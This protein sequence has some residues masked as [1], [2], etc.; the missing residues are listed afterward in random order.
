GGRYRLHERLGS[1]G[2]AD[3]YRGEHL[4]LKVPRAI[5][6]LHTRLT[7]ANL[8]KFEQEAR[9]VANLRHPNILQIHDFDV[10][11]GLPFLVMDYAPSGTLRDRHPQGSKLPPETVAVY[12]SYIADA[13]QFAHDQNPPIVHRDIKPENLL[14]GSRGEIL[15]SDFGI[16]TITTTLAPNPQNVAGTAAY[17]APEQFQGNPRR[18][19]DQ[20][21]LG[22]VVY[23]WLCGTR[24]FKGDYL[25]LGYK[26]VHETP[27]PL[28]ASDKAPWLL[29]AVEQGV[30]KALAKDPKE[31]YPST[32]EF[33]GAFWSA[34]L[35]PP[36][37]PPI[38]KLLLTY[39]KHK[40]IVNAVAW[41]P[42][43]TRIASAGDDKTVQVWEALT[44]K[45]L[46]T[47]TEDSMAVNSLAW[48]PD[49]TRLVTG[50]DDGTIRVWNVLTGQPAL[51]LMDDPYEVISVSWSP[52]G[53]HVAIGRGEGIVEVWDTVK[54]KRLFHIQDDITGV[55][56]VTF[57][58]TSNHVA[59]GRNGLRNGLEIWDFSQAR[60]RFIYKNHVADVYTVA[61][62]PDG[63][64]IAS[65]GGDWLDSQA[66]DN[67]IHVWK[68]AS[69]QP[70]VIYRG[71]TNQV[72][73]AA[74][75]PD[76]RRIAS[77]SRDKTVQVWDAT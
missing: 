44:G 6:V 25:A 26:H 12:L 72:Q 50:S 22:V 48:S 66:Q 47:C 45:L 64:H 38:G 1:G 29:P 61:W 58:P 55:T 27:P 37:R 21:A 67:S 15:L 76:G 13:L 56:S 62:S 68:V 33:A 57:S 41:S 63:T 2:F 69:G 8:T 42:D 23:E 18:A 9:T 32:R 53:K 49:N 35:R 4:R 39:K 36:K 31:R 34:C 30:L 46:L 3:V 17:M 54:N 19:S 73:A 75:S 51:K 10:D 60:P 20:Y 71:H 5:K 77:A 43:G 74:W 24:P 59:F 28:R 70:L 52:D 11:N 65:G 40:G 7:G 14:I 16:A